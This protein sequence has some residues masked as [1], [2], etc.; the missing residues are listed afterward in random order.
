[1]ASNSV[2]SNAN[3]L[4]LNNNENSQGTMKLSTDEEENLEIHNDFLRI[5]PEEMEQIDKLIK[6]KSNSNKS[7]QE[8]L[9]E[10]SELTPIIDTSKEVDD[11]YYRLVAYSNGVYYKLGVKD[12]TS[13]TGSGYVSYKGRKAYGQFYSAATNATIGHTFTSI[14]SYTNV[15][16]GYDIIDSASPYSFY[17]CKNAY[18]HS[19][20][21]KENSSGKAYAKFYYDGRT[22][23][24]T[25]TGAVYNKFAFT[26]YVG[27]DT[28]SVS[29]NLR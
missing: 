12:G 16:G 17:Y 15:K 1:M 14:I 18:T 5:F 3:K 7:E 8:L 22:S 29:A 28:I 21:L 25:A 6:S 2:Y 9:E 27:A 13:T 4:E 24:N 11:N 23:Y 10:T 26:V 19:K 20:K